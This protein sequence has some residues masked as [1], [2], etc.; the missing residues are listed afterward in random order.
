MQ[1]NTEYLNQTPNK[2]PRDSGLKYVGVV[3]HG[4][5]GNPANPRGTLNYNLDPKIKSSYHDLI[6]SSGEWFQYLDPRK[7]IAWHAG[8]SYWVA[9]TREYSGAGINRHFIGV[10][11][12][13]TN[14]GKPA[15]AAQ[16]EAAARLALYYRDEYGIP[17][18]EP[19][20]VT[21]KQIAP[22]RKIDPTCCTV[23]AILTKAREI[24][25]MRTED[26]FGLAW[27][28]AFPYRKDWGIP[29]RWRHELE[30]GNDLGAATSDETSIGGWQVQCFQHGCIAWKD[31]ESKVTR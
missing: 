4:T 30:H 23:A 2:E 12:D 18:L 19:Y 11:L 20:H 7:Y 1:P 10:E 31:G 16:L 9:G 3:W 14:K 24:D 22:G 21:H 13:E 27:G 26:E 29:A 28:N 6:S 17:L 8:V 15:P 5:G 25:G